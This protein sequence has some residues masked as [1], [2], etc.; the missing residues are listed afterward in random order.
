[1]TA[2]INTDEERTTGYNSTLAIGW[3]SSPL[4]SFVVV[5]SSVLRMKYSGKNPAFRVAAKR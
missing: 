4:D 5:E 1:M 2:D 3:A